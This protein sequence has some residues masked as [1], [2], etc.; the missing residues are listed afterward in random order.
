MGSGHV[1]HRRTSSFNFHLNHGIVVFK[2]VQ[3][4]FNL[5]SLCICDNVTLFRPSIN[6]SVTISIWCWGWCC[7]SHCV[8]DCSALDHRLFFSTVNSH[9]LMGF[10]EECNTSN[11]TSYMSKA[12]IPP[13]RRDIVNIAQIKILVLGWNLGM[14]LNPSLTT[15]QRSRVGIPSMR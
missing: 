8:L 2:D 10:F 11:T 3:L 6:L 13:V 14:V 5:R 9:C 15:S 7:G 12:R 4:R 1:S